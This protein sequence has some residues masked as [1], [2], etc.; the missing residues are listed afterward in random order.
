MS[1]QTWSD[2]CW[3][4]G[5]AAFRSGTGVLE[6]TKEAAETF[7]DL[8]ADARD[9]ALHN[10]ALW[11][12]SRPY[13]YRWLKIQGREAAKAARRAGSTVILPHH[14][15]IGVQ[16]GLAREYK[17]LGADGTG[18]SWCRAAENK[19]TQTKVA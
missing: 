8:Y 15:E 1:V 3:A 18:T 9:L 4:E 17:I 12:Q 10:P 19:L 13:A 7:L 14:V 16:N 2:E 11:E 5:L 6:V